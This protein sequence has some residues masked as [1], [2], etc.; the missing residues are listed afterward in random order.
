MSSTKLLKGSFLIMISFFVF[1]VGGYIYRF[2]MSRFLGPDGY[3]LLGLTIPFQGIFQIL[4][5]GGLPPAIAKYVAEYKAL[6]ED[7]MVRQ[8]IFTSLKFMVVLGI[9]MSLLVF[10]SAPLIANNIFHKPAVTFPLQAVALITPFSVIVG[11]FRGAFQGLYKME[12]IVATRV[13]EQVF[14]ITGA[15]LLVSVGFYAAGAVLGTGFGFMASAIS[16]LIIFRMYLWKYLPKPDKMFN[17]IDELRLIKT[18]L[19]FS[20]PVIITA[21]SEMFIYDMATFV[22]GVYLA[23]NFIGYYTAADPIARLPLV[24]SLSVAT[25]VLPAASEA[26][27]LKDKRLLEN[28]IVQSY[29]YVILLVLPLCVGIALFSKPLLGILFGSDFV[30]GAEALS[31]LVIGMTFYTLFMV[32]AS[33]TQGLGHPRLPMI[34]LIGGTVLNLILNLIMVPIYGIVGAAIATSLAALTIMLVILWRTYKLTEIKPPFLDFGKILMASMIMGLPLILI[35]KTYSGFV[36]GL[37]I[38]PFI[39]LIALT[40]LRGFE[41]RDVRMLRRFKAKT[42]PFTIILD[43][44]IKFIEKFAK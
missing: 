9:L 24:I 33:I 35:P 4:S 27:A 42:G 1:R 19:V 41:K 34:I 14:M 12:Y 13:V 36:I 18:L 11:G 15:V 21:L 37:I 31:I 23:T 29:R 22:I 28:Y 44:L 20:I 39:Y 38:S 3:G 17:F 5:A 26:S 32:A 2:I 8:V 25:A 6:D 7:D 30:F 16:A 43:K 40:F 10:F